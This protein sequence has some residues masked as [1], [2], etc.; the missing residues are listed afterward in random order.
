MEELAHG[1][2]GN[3][4]PRSTVELGA[5]TAETRAVSLGLARPSEGTLPR[6][7]RP[8]LITAHPSADR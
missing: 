3:L 6:W 8:H 4:D 2:Y 5:G 7:R 1:V